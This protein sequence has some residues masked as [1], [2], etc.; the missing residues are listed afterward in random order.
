MATWKKVVVSGSNAELNT[1]RATSVTASLFGTAS[2]AVNAL[3]SLSSSFATTASYAL[4]AGTST[5]INTGSFATTGSNTFIGNQIVSGAVDIT[6]VLTVQNAITTPSG[7]YFVASSDTSTE[8]SWGIPFAPNIAVSSGIGSSAAGT[9][10]ANISTD[11]NGDALPTKT[12]VFNHAGNLIAPGAVSA[13]SFT[14]SLQGTASIAVTSSYAAVAVSASFA[15][16]AS[17]SNFALT[18]LSSSRAANA[19][20]VDSI[21]G[22]ITNNTDNRILTAGGGGTINGEANLTFDGTT[23][24][25]NGSVVISQ[26][27]TVNGTTTFINT[28]NLYVEDRFVLLASGSATATDGGIV[29]SAAANGNGF[30][31]GYDASADRWALEDAMNPTGSAFSATPTSYIVS[32]QSSTGAPATDPAYGG[33]TTGWGNIHVDTNTGEI[34]I[35]S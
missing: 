35:Y 32:A 28:Q 19:G 25:V 23:L 16:N 4:N 34:F 17:S 9:S 21:S 10:I 30:G 20:T 3:T 15:T 24:D 11:G 1:L 12:W 2:Y 22:N 31:F 8:M 6:G 29:I 33:S 7:Q 18:A 14:G 26:D 5:N 27:L 13:S